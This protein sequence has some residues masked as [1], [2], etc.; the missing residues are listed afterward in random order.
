MIIDPEYEQLKWLIRFI[1]A[2][3]T[4]SNV[5]LPVPQEPRPSLTSIH[6]QSSSD[7]QQIHVE[8]H[9]DEEKLEEQLDNENEIEKLRRA[10]QGLCINFGPSFK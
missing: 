5:C 6:N 9:D 4:S 1:K 10:H 8:G 3:S 7:G 2:R